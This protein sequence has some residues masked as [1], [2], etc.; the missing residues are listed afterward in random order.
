MGD[1]NTSQIKETGI[2]TN[3]SANISQESEKKKSKSVKDKMFIE[4][5]GGLSNNRIGIAYLPV[6]NSAGQIFAYTAYI[7]NHTTLDK[8]DVKKTSDSYIIELNGKQ[9]IGK[10][11][12]ISQNEYT[13]N[14]NVGASPSQCFHSALNWLSNGENIYAS[15]YIIHLEGIVNKEGSNK[16]TFTAKLNP[17]LVLGNIPLIAVNTRVDATVLRDFSAKNTS[18][19][20]AYKLDKTISGSPWW[21]TSLQGF[22]G[23]ATA[24]SAI[25]PIGMYFWIGGNIPKTDGLSAEGGVWIPWSVVTGESPAKDL[26]YNIGLK[27]KWGTETRWWR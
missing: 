14:D 1:M 4:T 3:K 24:K 5:S 12:V 23:I 26:K 2:Y 25:E 6:N 27:M 11:G 16:P 15:R 8:S 10:S 22:F 17:Y 7:N 21:G 9:V 19:E 13:Y 18:Y 20:C